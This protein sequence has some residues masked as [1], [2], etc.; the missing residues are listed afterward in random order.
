MNE[1][2]KWFLETESIPGEGTV[3]NVEMIT[4]NLEY[5]INLVDK[6]ATGFE[7]TDSNFE[8]GYKMGKML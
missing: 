2:Q 4:K 7:R 8:R 1:Q 3:K 5:H 6:T